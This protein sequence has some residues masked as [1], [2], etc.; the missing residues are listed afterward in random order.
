MQG[1]GGRATVGRSN[2][3]L[4]VQYAYAYANGHLLYIYQ[5]EYNDQG[6]SIQF[7]ECVC[8]LCISCAHCCGCVRVAERAQCINQIAQSFAASAASKVGSSLSFVRVRL[9]ACSLQSYSQVR[10]SDCAPMASGPQI[11]YMWRQRAFMFAY[12]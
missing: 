7:M 12:N 11:L 8:I 3:V 4:F 6:L 5:N 9:F 10:S 1:E 2:N